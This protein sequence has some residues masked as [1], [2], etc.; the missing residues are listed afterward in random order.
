MSEP[1]E[2]TYSS[3]R[4]ALPFLFPGQAQREFFVNE[5]FARLDAVTHPAVEA[6]MDSPPITPSI[7]QTWLIGQAPTDGW[8][9]RQGQL[10]TWQGS[11]WIFIEPVIGMAVFDKSVPQMRR[12]DGAWRSAQPVAL[13]TGGT[14]N[15]QEARAAIASLVAALVEAGILPDA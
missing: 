15:D 13:P 7:G 6:V 3:A 12:F 1:L 8:T 10:A 4:L 9:D 2:F 14:T 11:D 5:A